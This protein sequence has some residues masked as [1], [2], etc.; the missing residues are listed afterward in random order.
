MFNLNSE[1]KKD[2]INKLEEIIMINQNS[3][4]NLDIKLK[5]KLIH[6]YC[7]FINTQVSEDRTINTILNNPNKK[8]SERKISLGK[9]RDLLEEIGYLAHLSFTLYP[10]INLTLIH[11]IETKDELRSTG[12]ASKLID[13]TCG[14]IKETPRII[15]TSST[16]NKGTEFFGK[17]GFNKGYQK[18]V[19]EF[20]EAKE[21]LL[22]N[23]NA[24]YKIVR[25]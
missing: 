11:G 25:S 22:G 7:N 19:E 4:N 13:Y 24:M 14:I 17:K 23:I 8:I 15:V 6:H 3:W 5:I 16:S 20:K 1:L 2:I 21:Y 10:E 12:L 18:E 9:K